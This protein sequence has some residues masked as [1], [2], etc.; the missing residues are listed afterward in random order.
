MILFLLLVP[1][2]QFTKNARKCINS[3]SEGTKDELME[4]YW[5]NNNKRDRF[6]AVRDLQKFSQR[7]NYHEKLFEEGHDKFT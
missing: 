5:K 2:E 4:T 6:C 1:E 3:F 7:L